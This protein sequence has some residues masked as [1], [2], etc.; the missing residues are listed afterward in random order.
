MCAL[1]LARHSPPPSFD[2][3]GKRTASTAETSDPRKGSVAL[4]F[5]KSDA[6]LFIIVTFID[7]SSVQ[8]CML[9]HRFFGGWR[10]NGKKANIIHETK[11]RDCCL[12]WSILS[13]A[14]VFDR[15]RPLCLSAA[16]GRGRWASALCVPC[17]SA[18]EAEGEEE[19]GF[20]KGL[21]RARVAGLPSTHG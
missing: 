8:K 16:A 17:L 6:F 11:C 10:E 21:V 20:L 4:G 9:P 18:G 12:R 5:H 3:S 14:R 2:Q 15:S 1:G 13:C 7:P 19:A